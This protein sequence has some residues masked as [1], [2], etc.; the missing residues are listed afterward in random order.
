M[1]RQ[2]INLGNYANDGTGDDLRTAFEKVNANFIQVYNNILDTSATNLGNGT[3]IFAQKNPSTLDLEF[4]TLTSDDDTV[5]I[6]STAT[7]INLESTAKLESDTDPHLGGE[8]F[9]NGFVINGNNGTGDIQSTVYGLDIKIINALLEVAITTNA[10]NLEFGDN[11]ATIQN[12]TSPDVDLG[13][14][15]SPAIIN[16]DFGQWF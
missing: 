2:E 12:Q 13:S 9:L 8:L 6:T 5:A 3:A 14:F 7:T 15:T 11:S 10:I 1:A 4:K 16:L